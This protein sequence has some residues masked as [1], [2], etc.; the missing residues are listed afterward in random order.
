MPSLAV[1]PAFMMIPHGDEDEA[2]SQDGAEGDHDE[3]ELHAMK[4]FIAAI[5]AGDAAKALEAFKACHELDHE[6]R[7]DDLPEPEEGEGKDEEPE[8]E[9]AA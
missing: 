4:M 8:E 7:G 5:K 2:P 6:S 3:D 9:E 1:H